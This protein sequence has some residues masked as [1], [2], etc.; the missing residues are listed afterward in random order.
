MQAIVTKY[1]PP[2]NIRGARIKATA[3]AGS[4]TISYPHELRGQSCHRAAAQALADKFG[5][6]YAYLGGALPG[7]AKYVFVPVHPFSEE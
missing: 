1:L 2:S 5:W 6:K 7:R 3:E 4:V